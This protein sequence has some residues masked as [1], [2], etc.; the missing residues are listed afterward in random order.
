MRHVLLPLGLL[1]LASGCVTKKVH[2]ELENQLASTLSAQES[3]RATWVEELNELSMELAAA[4]TKIKGLESDLKNTNAALA[5]VE[6]KLKN[7][8]GERDSLLKEK[9]SLVSSKSKLEASIAETERALVELANRKAAAEQRIAQYRDLVARFQTLID[10]GKLRVRIIDGRMVV[11]LAT[12]VLFASGKADLSA[13]GKAAV[14][15]VASVLASMEDRRY[16]VEGHTDNVPIKTAQFPSNWELSSAR[17]LTV[18]RELMAAGVPA[19]RLSAAAYGE[20]RP[21]GPNE[22]KEERA[23]NRRIVRLSSANSTFMASR[24]SRLSRYRAASASPGVCPAGRCPRRPCQ[25]GLY[26]AP[27]HARGGPNHARSGSSG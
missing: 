3:E 14:V 16:Q 18:V 15:E 25:Q 17:A 20:F 5:T 1:L 10:A 26:H 11:E 12:D 2:T 13:D 21:A 22:T 8:T 6:K 4:H 23:S 19:E 9:A 7:M 27:S 24:S